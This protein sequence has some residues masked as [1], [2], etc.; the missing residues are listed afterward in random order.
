MALSDHVGLHTSSG[1]GGM[2][3]DEGARSVNRGVE[4]KTESQGTDVEKRRRGQTVRRQVEE[5]HWEGE[6]S[7]CEARRGGAKE[8]SRG[9]NGRAEKNITAVR[10]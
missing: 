5:T 2:R 4:G 3:R 8:R 6:R 1:Q 9:R 7:G 10:E